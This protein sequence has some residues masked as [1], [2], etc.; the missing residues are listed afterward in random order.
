MKDGWTAYLD[1]TGAMIIVGSSVVVGKVI[2]N[3]F[4]LFLAS[5]L[6]F[7]VASVLLIALASCRE[8]GFRDIRPKDWMTLI[9]MALS[10]QF[11]FTLFVLWGLRFTNAIDA[12]II[13][14]TTPAA[15]ALISY[16]VLRERPLFV[17]GCGVC[18][19]ILGVIAVNDLLVPAEAS[20]AAHR[21]FGNGLVCAAVFGEA[22]FLLLRK[23]VPS[24]VSNMAMTAALCLIGF[25]MSLPLAVYEAWTFDFSQVGL[26]QWGSILYFGLIFTVVAYLLWFRGVAQ[27][28]GNTAGIFTAVMPVSALVLSYILLDEPF[29]WSQALGCL[30]VVSAIALMTLG[31]RPEVTRSSAS[32]S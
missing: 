32:P 8:R 26:V 4:P 11:I 9:L 16:L 14:S 31:P 2:T 29:K 1:L 24:S 12:G 17:H 15:M 20:H 5:A 30:L 3:C 28:S 25:I 13:M 18:L 6:R 27:V 10:G 23:R 7:G 21:W 22:L 19:A